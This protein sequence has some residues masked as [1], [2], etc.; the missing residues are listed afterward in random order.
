MPAARRVLIVLVAPI[1]LFALL[2]GS[3]VADGGDG[4]FTGT[5]VGL[6]SDDFAHNRSTFRYALETAQGTFELRFVDDAPLIS[7]SS[8]VAVRGSRS[9]NTI[10]VAAG[11]MH[12]AGSTTSTAPATGARKVAVILVTF[13]DNPAQPYTPAFA[14]G[15]AFTNSNS[16]AAYYSAASWG[17]LTLS[18]DVFGWYQ[19]S[20][21]ST[22]CDYSTW[23]SEADSAAKA[24]G[25][26]LSGYTNFV[27]GF[28]NTPA[29][30]WAGLAYMPG[31]QAWLNGTSGMNLHGMA[32]ELGHNLGTHH[33]NAYYCTGSGVRVS[34]SASTANCTS[35]EYG[36]PFSVMGNYS[37]SSHYEH[38]NF[39]RG[40]LGWLSAASTLDVGS[41]GTY[42]LDPIEPSDPTG[43]QA[44]RIK[45]DSST[46]F[47]LELRQPSNP[48]DSFATIDPAVNG[49]MIRI[50]PSYS[51]VSQ[52]QL[53]DATPETAS[54]GDAALAVGRS[55]YDPVSKVTITTAAISSSGATVLISF[56]GSVADTTP[57]TTPTGLTA[58]ATD[59]THVALAWAASADN[60]GVVGYKV[61]RGGSYL[62]TATSTSYVDATAVPGT[63]F[64]YTVTAVDAAGN[65]SNASNPAS[66]T[67][68]S[69]AD[70]TSPSAPAN[71][72]A[73][74]IRNRPQVA[75]SWNAATDDVGVAGY[76]VYLNG[77]PV[78]TLVGNTLNFTT[79]AP[80]GTDSYYVVAFDL[81]GNVS[82][83]SSTAIVSV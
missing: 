43:P 54:Y 55:L 9:G 6:H 11:G 20:A 68:S 75:L 14:Q 34:L 30:S 25:V 17:Q 70:T 82:A 72:T 65:E 1:A 77:S 21:K 44:L 2:A 56:G 48:F 80:K 79:K 52:S 47:L 67:T 60:I 81:A 19:I 45:R 5:L 69:T 50:V 83:N 61:S 66:A 40:N 57:P 71:L 23:A 78:A 12:S 33:A 15:V 27:Y 41:S 31:S 13:A 76:Q 4:T 42:T 32:H 7:R 3:S 18:G 51:L 36:D 46:Y 35:Q 73:T 10:I 74:Q 38:T 24:A 39:A 59:T 37:S 8:E 49:V 63:T 62:A 16:V 29:C 64:S 22:T 28:P 58:A 26:N 53:V